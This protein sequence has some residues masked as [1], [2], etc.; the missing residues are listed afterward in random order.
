M[1]QFRSYF[2]FIFVLWSF[3]LE[4]ASRNSPESQAKR[5]L[6]PIDLK[7][8][9]WYGRKGFRA[10]W[11][12][13]GFKDEERIHNSF[14]LLMNVIFREE[15]QGL[16]KEYSLIARFPLDKSKLDASLE[17]F[18]EQI[19]EN[20]E[21]YLNGNLLRSELH[22][23][24]DG[25]GLARYKVRKNMRVDLP[26]PFLV[27]G[28]NLLFFRIIGH[29]PIGPL[30]RNNLSGLEGYNYSIDFVNQ[31]GST[32]VEIRGVLISILFSV[33]LFFI[34]IFARVRSQRYLLTM[35]LF[36]LIMAMF[37]V[38]RFGYIDTWFDDTR[39]KISL[40]YISLAWIFPLL[41]ISIEFFFFYGQKPPFGSWLMLSTAPLW[42][43]AYCLTPFLMNQQLIRLWQILN[44]ILALWPLLRMWQAV[45]TDRPDAKK[46]F[47]LFVLGMLANIIESSQTA[48]NLVTFDFG[49]VASIGL[50]FTMLSVL[51]NH[52]LRSEQALQLLNQ[53]L[54]QEKLAI[55]RFIP[56]QFLAYLG[57]DSITSVQLGDQ[58]QRE[59]SIMFID[60]RSFTRLSELM[61]PQ[62]NFNFLN[63]YFRRVGPIIRK[64]EGFIDKYIG[65][66]IMA[67]F[68]VHL[69]QALLAAIA[70]QEEMLVYNQHR[71]KQNYQPIDVT[72]GIHVGQLMLGMV[73]ESERI[74]GT[75]ISDSVNV[76]SR[77]EGVGKTYNAR[78]VVSGSYLHRL[79]KKPL[80]T[81]K[82]GQVPLKGKSNMIDIYE[83][84]EGAPAL[85]YQQKLEHILA[86]N[87][88]M[89]WLESGRREEAITSLRDIALQ[90]P[91]DKT[92]QILIGMLERAD[93][94]GAA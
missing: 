70:I 17:L 21:I 57:K 67:L 40:E 86:F 56:S 15:S 39:T 35:G 43:L 41:T 22:L 13:Q 65:D 46:G 61:T 74:D 3:G 52:F 87:Q 2:I 53:R 7:D 5:Q 12:T 76:A 38:L 68:P 72:I 63:S 85:E 23:D 6:F 20:W 78:I 92:V 84:F 64:H 94:H 11:V 25:R 19:G 30:N 16:L 54:L 34:T 75:V 58:T 14:P 31:P 93:I 9:D 47:T 49:H 4:A 55:S 28:T 36:L 88:A 73:G 10:D 33:G 18:I 32:T 89:E 60:I 27:D 82:L 1:V 45:R 83:I 69:E 24:E 71:L 50:V 42:T 80:A 62:E 44:P 81:R 90:C 79:D 91:D 59:M 51:V 37:Y 8:L 29:Q 77:L 26:Y 48:L 66:G